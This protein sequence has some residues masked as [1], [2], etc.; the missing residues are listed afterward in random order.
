MDQFTVEAR[1][2]FSPKRPEQFRTSPNLLFSESREAVSRGVKWPGRDADH[3]ALYIAQRLRV[4]GATHVLPICLHGVH[5]DNRVL[6][7]KVE[8][9]DYGHKTSHFTV[10]KK[11][12]T[13]IL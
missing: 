4:C 7:R 11:I 6:F 12:L 9:V 8:Y 13:K 2:L 1:I 10:C 5:W 3:S